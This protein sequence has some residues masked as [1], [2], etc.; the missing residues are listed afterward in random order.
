MGAAATGVRGSGLSFGFARG[1]RSSAKHVGALEREN[2][3]LSRRCGGCGGA[4]GSAFWG[5]ADTL[6]WSS[7]SGPSL[8]GWKDQTAMRFSRTRFAANPGFTLWSLVLCAAS[9]CG[10]ASITYDVNLTVGAASVTGTITTDGT[11]GVLN[12]LGSPSNILDW[13]LVLNDPTVYSSGSPCSHLPCTADLGPAV[14]GEAPGEDINSGADLSATATQL[15][16]NFSGAD[17]GYFFFETGNYGAVCFETATNCLSPGFGAG[18]SLYI[19]PNFDFN[20]DLQF[21]GLSGTQV[22]GTSSSAG[23]PEPSTLALLCAGIALLGF[24][25]HANK[26]RRAEPTTTLD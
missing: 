6:E 26:E 4:V 22:L 20:S 17:G 1:Y 8:S 5:D 18:E 21:A 7:G 16:F 10:A 24:S 15:L 3:R 9:S 23:T 14:P 19:D 13:D 12:S 2:P 11:I 25:R